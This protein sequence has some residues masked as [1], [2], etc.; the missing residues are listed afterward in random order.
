MDCPR[1]GAPALTTPECPACGVLLAK[2]RPARPR[3]D[4]DASLPPPPAAWR[5]LVL[6]ALGFAVLAAAATAYLH[7]ASPPGPAEPPLADP[8]GLTGPAPQAPEPL[9]DPELPPA[10]PL[11][12][13]AA[14]ALGAPAARDP[15]AAADQEAAERLASR[16]KA[17]APLSS[18][19][20]RAAEGLF[21]R[22]PAAARDLLEAV[23]LAAA[24]TQTQ[25]RR[26]DTAAALVERA[27][28]VAP[29]SPHSRRALLDVRLGAGDWLAAEQ[30]G[31]ALLA[32]RPD[33]PAGAKGLAQAL[34]RQDRS[35]EAIEIL[36]AFLNLREDQA[37]R[38]F[39]NRLEHDQT[40]EQGLDEAKLAHFHVRYDGDAHEDVGREIL[41][42]LERH[43]ATLARSFDYQP[44]QPVP[45]ILLSSQSYYDATGAPAWS[46]GQYDSFD[47]RIRVP[48][49]GL[50]ASLSPEL[51]GT[52]V[53]ELTHSFV[54]DLSRGLAPRELQEGLA[55]YME[56][57]R[58]SQL[59]A[60][61]L[62][63]LA[64]GRLSGVSGFYFGAL[65]LVEDLLGQRGQGGINDLLRAMASGGGLD[66]AFRGVYGRD[67]AGMQR[68][69]AERL[70]QRHGS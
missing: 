54:A 61:R 58:M 10:L 37:T 51:D 21:V 4:R 8:R 19:D 56:G 28:G 33:D 69:A 47:G 11:P 7:Q 20:V 2:A 60:E 65:W 70:R 57:R 55:Q 52:L 3:R 6:P 42:L 34:V 45:V 25:A 41:R 15:A 68:Q 38:A 49:G 64:D 12:P 46:A 44:T 14:V 39:L 53:H 59:D 66:E 1:C 35:R 13:P 30:A 29:Q 63:A 24:S 67:F 36:T 16:L 48:I 40:S 17:R 18:E 26:F 32:L 9:A 5:S 27:V 50:S 23:L 62:R 22:Y 31:R 43:Y